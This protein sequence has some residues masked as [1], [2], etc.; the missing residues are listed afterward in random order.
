ME[1]DL[2]GLVRRFNRTVTQRIGAL[3]EEQLLTAGLA[4]IG[5]QD[6][7]SSAAQFC[8]QSYF[9]ELDS[10]F[11]AGFD[12]DASISAAASELAEPAGLLLLAHI[13]GEP[14]GCGALKLHGT[15]PA[16]LKRMWVAASARG[17]GVGRRILTELERRA[18]ERGATVVRLETNHALTEAIHLYRSAGY[19]EVPAFNHEPYAHH[20]FEK[21][22]TN[23]CGS[24][25]I[26]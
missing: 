18:R 22:L 21:H 5:V 25:S 19:V 10:R 12:P 4:E 23:R 8:L 2:I 14:V 3:H 13:H 26:E 20:W 9:A 7:A 1:R 6:P 17:L 24:V 15:E 11:D 16:E